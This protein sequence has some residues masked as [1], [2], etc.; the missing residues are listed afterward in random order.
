MASNPVSKLTEEQ[1]LAIERE[2]EFRSEFVD[3]EML[4]MSGGSLRHAR[5]QQNISSELYI[6]LRDT[7]CEAFTSD[8]RVRV[9]KTRMYAYPDVSVICGKPVLADDHLD[10]LLNPIV[11]FEVLSPTTEKYDRGV[12]SQH[13]RAIES[14]KDYILVD[15]NQ[16]RIEQFTRQDANTWTLR[17][18]QLLDQELTIASIGISLP[19]RRIYD[20]IELPGA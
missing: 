4:A 19:L 2:A 1:Y 18:Y 9:P 12:K 16:V 15:Q 10:N 5:L 8:M 6:A 3:G 17:D 20:R 11:I 13:Y 14:L 7:G